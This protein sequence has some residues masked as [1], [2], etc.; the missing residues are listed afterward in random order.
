M[1][2]QVNMSIRKCNKKMKNEESKDVCIKN[3]KRRKKKWKSGINK[4][5]KM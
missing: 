3:E 5:G 4:A 2:E 1:W